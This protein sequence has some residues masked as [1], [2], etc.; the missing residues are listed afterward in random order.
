MQSN[1]LLQESISSRLHRSKVNGKHTKAYTTW[2][3]IIT[4]CYNPKRHDLQ[5]FYRDCE[6]SEDWRDFQNFADWFYSHDYSD[7]GYQ[8]DKDLLV[9]NNRLYS[10]DTVCF[11]PQE[12]NK[13]ITIRNKSNGRKLGTSFHKSKGSWS[14]QISIKSKMLH[15]GYFDNELDAH[16]EFMRCKKQYIRDMAIEWRERIEPKA[17]DALMVRY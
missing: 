5:P 16:L 10:K 6:I 8:I 11:L 4:R 13:L 3:N 12:I 17:F 7:M 1:K 9:I 2:S 14:A 15:L